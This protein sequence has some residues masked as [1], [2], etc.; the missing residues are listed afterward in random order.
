MKNNEENKGNTFLSVQGEMAELTRKKDWSKTSLGAIGTWQQSLKT[1]VSTILN[2][3]F[4]MF[5]FWGQDLICFYNDAYRPSLGQD[6]KHPSMLGMRG[7]E[8]WTEIWDIIK[9][10]ID[11]VMGGGEATWSEDQLV[12]IYRNGRI[13]DVYWSFSYS[14]VND[15]SG[16]IGG[17]LVTCNETTNNV[18]TKNILEESERRLRSMILQAPLAIG[19]TR[20]EN[21]LIEIANSKALELWGRT[22]E[23]VLH[24]PILDAMPELKS[25]RIKELLDDVYK[26]GKTFTANER[27]VLI[28]RNG[29]LE[30]AYINFSYEAL[31]NANGKIDGIMAS[32]VE[33]TDQVQAR[34]KI[35]ESKAE[36]QNIFKQAPVTIVVYK[37]EDHIV[38][39]ANTAA[40]EMWGKSESD[41]LHKPFF[42][43]SPE[44]KDTQGP[45]LTN[46]YRTGEPFFANEF[47]VT[48][49]KKGSPYSGYFN[50]VYQPLRNS[51]NEITGVMGIGTE[52][53]EAVLNRQKIEASEK[54][55]RLLADSMPQHIWTADSEGNLNYYNQSVFD[56]TG[57]SFQE[58]I[59]DGWK[60]FVHPDDLEKNLEEWNNAVATG[61][62]YLFEQRFRKHDGEYRWQLSRAKPQRAEDGTI[63]MWVGTSTDIQAQVDFRDEL[64]KEVKQRTAELVLLNESLKASEERYHLMVQEVQDYAILYINR[65]GIVENWNSGAEKI[66]GYKAEEIIGK[67]FSNFYTDEDRKNNLPQKLLNKAFLKNKAVQEGWRKKKDGSL[68]WASVLITA[69]HNEEGDVIGFSKVTHDLTDKKNAD[70]LMKLKSAQLE[71]K[72]IELDKMNKELQSFAYI[73]SHDLQEPLRK[74]QT[75]ASRIVDKE[76]DNLSEQGNELFH[77]MQSSAERMQSLIDD[78]LAYSRTHTSELSFKK[79]NLKSLIEKITQDLKEEIEQKNATIITKN[80]CEIH[81]IPFQIQQVFYNLFSNSLKFSKPEDPLK[82]TIECEITKGTMLEIENID[83]NTTYCH[84]KFADNGIGF[85]QQYSEKIFQ[86]FQRLFGRNEYNGTGIGLAIVKRIIENHK[87]VITA[88]GEEGKGATFD[89]YLPFK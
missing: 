89:I 17:V 31:F 23:E 67:S 26:T 87:G 48:Y 59:K 33:V 22:E 21:Y 56:Y 44:L 63:K 83:D 54:S 61:K 49:D 80:L 8:A 10:L 34:N 36:L 62:D 2:T 73:S 45:L 43:I 84:I 1:L 35:Q 77:R 11:Q 4:P 28:N 76:K 41:V 55:F 46:V 14:P 12:P 74:I 3:K 68:F 58:I 75:F 65:K 32:G 16:E 57:L 88:K 50:F 38:E 5:L 78:L 72:N 70:D 6:G 20:G 9:P 86:I 39:V 15:D 7:E 27:P 47:Q 71:Q 40:L 69:V 42:E 13:E 30:T 79:L 24:K 82:I 85:E 19:I 51:D 53:T 52:V 66:K 60:L 81:V 37:G 18:I 29:T 64:E 25:Q